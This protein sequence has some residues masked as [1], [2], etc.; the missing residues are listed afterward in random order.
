MNYWLYIGLV[1]VAVLWAVLDILE[2]ENFFASV[3]KNLNPKF[4][5][6]ME[7]WKTTGYPISINIPFFT[8]KFG[9]RIKFTIP[10]KYFGWRFDAWHITKS[11]IICIILIPIAHNLLEYIVMGILFNFVFSLSYKL[12]KTK[13]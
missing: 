7:S 5:Y 12:L 10:A 1:I 11:L 13:T 2:N 6:K 8:R 4:F 9:W 3:F